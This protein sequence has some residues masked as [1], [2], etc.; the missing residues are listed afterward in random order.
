M[1]LIVRRDPNPNN[2]NGGGVLLQYVNAVGIVICNK[3]E[4]PLCKNSLIKEFKCDV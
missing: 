3:I 1:M 2:N 4:E